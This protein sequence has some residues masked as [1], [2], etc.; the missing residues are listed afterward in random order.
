MHGGWQIAQH[1][2]FGLSVKNDE[3]SRWR[4]VSARGRQ[5]QL[6]WIRRSEVEADICCC[7]V[8]YYS[9]LDALL[10]TGGPVL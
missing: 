1:R 3:R 7:I 6:I 4:E 10:K 2:L 5:G 8:C 9:I